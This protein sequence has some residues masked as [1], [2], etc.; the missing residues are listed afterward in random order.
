MQV[1]E[2]ERD[3]AT[4]PLT[5]LER[6]IIDAFLAVDVPGVEALRE[7]VPSLR[8][9]PEYSCV[10]GCGSIDLV[11]DR[12]LPASGTP[13]PVPVGADIVDEAD[14]PIGGLILFVRSGY[15]ADLEVHS[16][17]PRLQLPPL[18]RIRWGYPN[19]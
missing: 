13:N 12:C 19:A 10:C 17:G 4:R 3:L 2:P 8:A 16:W 9:N 7:Q 6:A 5:E 18:D 15:L 14:E 1:M 11:P